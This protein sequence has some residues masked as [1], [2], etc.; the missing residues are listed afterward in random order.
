MVVHAPAYSTGLPAA[1][2]LARAALL[3][4]PSPTTAPRRPARMEVHVPT[5]STRL[6]AHVQQGSG[7]P[8]A[9]STTAR[10]TRAF[11][12]HALTT[13]RPTVA[14]AIL[15]TVARCARLSSISAIAILAKTA[16]LALLSSIASSVNAPLATRARSAR[17][18][19]ATAM[20]ARTAAFVSTALLRA[21]AR[22]QDIQEPSAPFQQALSVRVPHLAAQ[23]QQTLLLLGSLSPWW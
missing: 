6:R 5:Q 8:H 7:A 10:Q 16:P 3:A 13:S 12:E 18:A 17:I 2:L 19:G 21:T 9:R 4:P 20:C 23:L 22:A 1:V 15:A 11:M 14:L